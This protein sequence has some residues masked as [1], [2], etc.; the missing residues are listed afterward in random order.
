MSEQR[1]AVIKNA[2][3]SDT[4]QQDAVDVA[5]KALTEFNIEKVRLCWPK[6]KQSSSQMFA[7]TSLFLQDVACCIKKEFDKKHGGTW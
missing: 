3:M 2:D 5:S 7:Y 4:M 1:K 6:K